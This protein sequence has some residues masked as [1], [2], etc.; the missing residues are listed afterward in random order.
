MP[1]LTLLLLIGALPLTSE[2]VQLEVSEKTPILESRPWGR[3]GAY[4]KVVGKA[5]F[6]LDPANEANR[7]ITD[8]DHAPRNADGKVEFST[9]FYLI[10]PA[11][12]GLGN[13][14]ILC[15]IGNRGRKG[16]LSMFSQAGGSLDPSSEAHFGDGWLLEEGYSL[17][18]VGWQFDPPHRP[19]LMHS[20]PATAV[21]ENGE[22]IRGLVRS[23]FV[24]TDRVYDHTLADRDH[25]A[26]E[27]AD[28]DSDSNILTVRDAVTA[29]RT[30]IPRK[31][32]KFAHMDGGKP[33]AD[34][35]RVWL[36]GGFEP[37]KI[38]EVVY[39]AQNPPVVGLGAAAVRDF[40]SFM[41]DSSSEELGVS[42]SHYNRAIGFGTSQ[43]GR[44]LRTFLYYGFNRNEQGERAFDGVMAHVAGGG[45]GSFNHRF[46]QP[47][48]DAH[49]FLNFLYPTD[50]FPFS[51]GPQFDPDLGI[52]GSI[53][54]AYETSPE[55]LPK[56]FYTNSSYEYWGR[57]ASLIHTTIDGKSDIEIPE[58]VRIYHFAGS[59]HGPAGFPP[60]PSIGQQPSNPMDFRWAMRALLWRMNQWISPDG[61]DPPASRY[62]KTAD[63]TLVTPE[64]L[65]FPALPGVNFSTRIHKAYKVDYGDRFYSEGIVDNEPPKIEGEYPMFVPAVDSDGNEVAGIRLPEQQVPLATY[66]GWNLFNEKSGPTDEISSMQGSYIRFAKTK[67]EREAS[68]DPRPSIEERYPTR[69]DYL[70]KVAEAAL[71][72]AKDGYLLERDVAAVIA[73][74]R[75]HWDYAVGE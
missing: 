21:G 19:G 10:K 4:E 31:R 47:S 28:P 46:A 5:H 25:V 72:L 32:W 49:P 29:E 41:K 26:Y 11:D 60:R 37:G 14:S 52:G 1:R 56:V 13:R 27:V 54:G 55:L 40:V 43:S 44:F 50:I 68:G 59:Q 24:V 20:Y 35:G 39:E 75:R 53:L 71:E 65:A 3:I 57:A 23:D 8:I 67:A 16:T 33:V 69:S 30:V 38:Y 2:V 70:G 62:G 22:P 34:A 61:V 17:L 7:V 66:C 51:D 74:A 45:R 63:N 6:A 9:D 12:A 18:W 15:E 42:G 64:A 48:R 73:N 58:N 36:K